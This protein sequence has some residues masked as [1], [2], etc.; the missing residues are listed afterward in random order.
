MN[1]RCF[2]AIGI[3]ENIL[4]N[5]TELIDL[6]RKNDAD[7]KWIKPHNIHLTLKF[8]GNTPQ[9]LLTEIKESLSEAVSFYSPF[10]IKIYGTGVF[11][12]KKYP[13]VIWIGIKESDILVNLRNSIENSVSQLGYLKDE[14][15][16]NPHLTIGRVRSQK[17]VANVINMLDNFRDK[18]FGNIFV[19]SIKL[20]KSD[21]KPSGAEYSCLYDIP[22]IRRKN[23]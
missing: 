9:H 21:L 11:P 2:I 22:I 15:E 8:L 3:P 4:T 7:I 19:D 23:D 17:G 5:I 14:K 10:Y 12:N 6:L 20:I 18:D 16:F 13:R 1:L